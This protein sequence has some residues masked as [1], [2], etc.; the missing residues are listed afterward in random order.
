MTE[1]VDDILRERDYFRR[2]CDELG[3]R[4]LRLLQERD[5]AAFDARRSRMVAGLVRQTYALCDSVGSAAEVGRPFLDIILA[6]TYF[7]RGAILRQDPESGAFHRLHFSGFPT[8]CPGRFPVLE[9][10]PP[11]LLVNAAT[12]SSEV[13]ERLREG[14]GVPYFLWAFDGASR[15]A[16]ILGNRLELGVFGRLEKED[17]E[18]A[19]AA[20]GVFCSTV[21]RK[22]AETALKDAKEMLEARVQERT[23]ELFA[24]VSERRQA[25][26]DLAA[27]EARLRGAVESSRDGFALFDAEDRIVMANEAYKQLNPWADEFLSRRSSFEEVV[28]I[29]IARGNV[30]EAEGREEEYMRERVRCHREPGEQSLLFTTAA[31]RKLLISEFRTPCGD[32]VVAFSDL[33]DLILAQEQTQRLQTE[34]AHVARLNTMG[35]MAAGFAHEINQP[36][37][38]IASYAMGCVRRF[39]TGKADYGEMVKVLCR[40]AGQAERAGEINRRIRRFLQ[41]EELDRAAIDVNRAI[42]EAVGLL[43]SVAEEHR[44]AICL[45]LDPCVPPVLAD[46]VQIQQVVLNLT[47]NGIEA[48][49]FGQSGPRRVT[50]CT[51][52]SGG[53]QVRIEVF[54]TGSGVPSEVRDRL[55]EPFFTTKQ[56]GMGVGLLVCRRI[57]EAHGGAL[58][59]RPNGHRGTR[60]W[61]CL[62]SAEVK[63]EA[64]GLVDVLAVEVA[65][66]NPGRRARQG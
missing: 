46:S 40:I 66:E 41:K 50:V 29:N 18:V 8:G 45:D 1:D 62:P 20:L 7:D 4:N 43:A 61:F 64:I 58:L 36:L 24:E 9:N 15:Y 35:E 59:L 10:P 51:R 47:R 31:G 26:R 25:Q 60:A 49:P 30:R 28:R 55:F 12:E 6:S 33:T 52:R 3:A 38:A 56:A 19:A 5:D 16:L 42:E 34:L 37:A 14:V 57:V 65:P 48:I 63:A 17:A 13:V 32:T 53:R 23:R 22:E 27:S 54:D 44:V 11:V 21:R 2:Q 39:K